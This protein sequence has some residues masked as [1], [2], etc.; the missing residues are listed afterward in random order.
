MQTSMTC[1]QGEKM[2]V[3]VPG[4]VLLLIHCSRHPSPSMTLSKWLEI[5]KLCCICFV[6]R[7]VAELEMYLFI[8][9]VSFSCLQSIKSI[10]MFW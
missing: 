2:T 10:L 5:V 6:G 8:C 1:P 4:L 3:I 7:R 9:K